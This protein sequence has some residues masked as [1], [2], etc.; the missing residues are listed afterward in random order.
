MSQTLRICLQRVALPFIFLSVKQR[1]HYFSMSETAPTIYAA[2]FLEK[3]ANFY[4]CWLCVVWLTR[5]KTS[6]FWPLV[7]PDNDGANTIKRFIRPHSKFTNSVLWS[8]VLEGKAHLAGFF[9]KSAGSGCWL[10]GGRDGLGRHLV[11]PLL[12]VNCSYFALF[13]EVTWHY[14][15]F[16][17]FHVV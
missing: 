17:L 15:P 9:W 7:Q 11:P 12:A 1:Q 2:H 14:N 13:C 4:I 10:V 8:W 16:Y 6:R 3:Y 5:Y